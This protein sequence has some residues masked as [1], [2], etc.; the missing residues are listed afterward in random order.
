MK[1]L[2]TYEELDYNNI[3][4]GDYILWRTNLNKSFYIFQLN[5]MNDNLTLLNCYNDLSGSI[6]KSTEP[7]IDYRRPLE[8]FI[9]G[10]SKNIM[11]YSENID[12]VLKE[13][14]IMSA[15]KKYNI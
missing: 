8:E 11:Y 9:S 4:Y 3:K 1:H 12:D 10:M 14:K 7:S 15:S 13:M 5:K 6:K 2:R